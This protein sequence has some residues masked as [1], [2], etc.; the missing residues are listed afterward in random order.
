MLRKEI[1][2]PFN[3]D[4]VE[5]S[6]DLSSIFVGMYEYDEASS[7]RGGG[8]MILD[9]EGNLKLEEKT[10]YGCLDAKWV[11]NDIISIACS[12]GFLRWFSYADDNVFHETPCV[13]A[14]NSNDTS[15]IIMTIDTVQENTACITAKGQLLFLKNTDVVQSWQAHSPVFESWCCALNPSGNIV[16][17]GSDD[18]SL[19]YWDTRSC[20]LILSDKR[21]HRMGTTAVEFLSDVT[22]LSGSYD[23]Y[24]REFDI[25]NQSTP[26]REIKSIGGIWRIKPFEDKLYV[27]ACYGG[28]QVL[29]LTNLEIIL[30]FYSGHQSMA[31]GIGALGNSQAASC[32]FYDKSVQIWSF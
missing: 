5:V 22:L 7:T 28:C 15:N 25:R 19:N 16:V 26:V 13:L 4:S 12:D 17:S 24:I 21:N 23:E 27:A 14:P 8:F 6:P 9:S 20:E 18:C 32:S 2:T 3:A 29:R 1:K 11:S 30:P 31:Y 10:E